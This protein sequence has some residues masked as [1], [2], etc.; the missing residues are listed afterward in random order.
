MEKNNNQKF[1]TLGLMYDN[2]I[3]VTT[4]KT[5]QNIEEG[6]REITKHLCEKN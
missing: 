1:G 5:Y 2:Y 6:S 3:K 4:R